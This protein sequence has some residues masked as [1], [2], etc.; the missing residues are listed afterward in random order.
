MSVT[1]FIATQA[2]AVAIALNMVRY[3]KRRHRHRWAYIGLHNWQCVG[4]LKVKLD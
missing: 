4:C 1:D 2:L 3:Y